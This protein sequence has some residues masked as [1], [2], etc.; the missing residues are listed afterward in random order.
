MKSQDS[1]VPRNLSLGCGGS[2]MQAPNT[3]C[4]VSCTTS[5]TGQ[6]SRAH[7]RYS[8]PSEKPCV[9]VEKARLQVCPWIRGGMWRYRSFRWSSE[10]SWD[11]SD[12]SG[13][14]RSVSMLLRVMVLW[15]TF[16]LWLAVLML[17]TSSST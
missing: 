4:S 3:A 14:K 9:C 5:S 10:K 11:G 13:R 15:I 12:M 8:E 1:P 2:E 6:S 16:R 17:P 7:A